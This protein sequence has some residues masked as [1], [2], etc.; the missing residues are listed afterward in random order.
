MKENSGLIFD[1]YNDMLLNVIPHLNS[2]HKIHG[3]EGVAYFLDGDFVV[4]EYLDTD[5]W[6]MFDIVF[7]TYCEEMQKFANEGY[8]VPKIYAWLKIPNM[9]HYTSGQPNKNKY[10]ILEEKVKGRSLYYGFLE[11]FYPECVHKFTKRQFLNIVHNPNENLI[12]I[13]E[14]VRMYLKDYI[15]MNEFLESVSEEELARLVVS[16]YDLHIKGEHSEPDLY[17]CNVLVDGEKMNIIDTHIYVDSEDRRIPPNILIDSFF[18]NLINLFVY[19]DNVKRLENAV[20]Y[21]LDKSNQRDYSYYKQKNN[22]VS[23]AAIE[24]V[25][26]VMNKYCDSPTL[27]NPK[28]YMSAFNTLQ[29]FL[30]KR[31]AA[32]VLKNVNMSFEP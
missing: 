1:S 14:I 15:Q 22:K 4:K 21:G 20:L 12:Q 5:N 16:A 10:Y 13:D 26:K 18:I 32:E 23:K 31:K 25:L 2:Y 6:Q 9:G 7:S 11:E 27:T 8:N 29:S 3:G 28:A 17:P 24:R 19:N 30:G